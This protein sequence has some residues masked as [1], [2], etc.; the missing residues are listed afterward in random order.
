MWQF[1]TEC[2]LMIVLYAGVLVSRETIQ[3]QLGGNINPDTPFAISDKD[4][5]GN[6]RAIWA[7]LP[8]GNV[9]DAFSAG[10]AFE[11]TYAKAFV[12]STYQL[13]EEFARPSHRHWVS[14]RLST[15]PALYYGYWAGVSPSLLEAELV[16]AHRPLAIG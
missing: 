4:K 16:I 2:Q 1:A 8:Q 6:V 13:W 15:Y 7:W 5:D 12:V 9:F 14:P 3:S 11:T 10:G